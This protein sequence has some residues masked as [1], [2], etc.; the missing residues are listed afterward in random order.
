MS[1]YALFVE[2]L[3]TMIYKYGFVG[4]FT[5]S[6]ISNAIPYFTVPY[7]FIIA[8]YSSLVREEIIRVFIVLFSALGASFGKIIVYLIG[9]SFRQLVS[10]NTKRNLETIS[11]YF[12]KSTFITVLVFAS[13]PLPDDIVCLPIGVMKYDLVKFFIALFIGKLIVSSLVIYYGSLAFLLIEALGETPYYISVPILIL[14]TIYVSYL[15]ISIDWFKLVITLRERG[16]GRFIYM[17]FREIVITTINL[18]RKMIIRK[19]S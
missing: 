1:E 3:K 2:H 4:V 13:L 18:V 17:L 8:I 14:L 7:L 9:Y 15:I 16:I 19:L 11:K 10:E 5:V 6:L 12:G